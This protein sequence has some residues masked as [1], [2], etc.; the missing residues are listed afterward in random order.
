MAEAPL[1]ADGS[2]EHDKLRVY[3]GFACIHCPFRTISRQLMRRHLSSP[4]D[5]CRFKADHARPRPR[6][7]LD[8]QFECVY[9]QTWTTGSTRRYWII[10]RGGSAVRPVDGPAVQAHLR[11]VL[12]RELDR[13]QRPAAAEP[14][15]EMT[16]FALQRPWMERTGWDQTYR[17]RGR[18]QVLAAMTRTFT[19]PGGQEYLLGR[20]GVCGLDEDLVS[21][22]GD[23]DRIASLVRLADVMI[24]RCE[25]TVRKTSRHVLCWLR[26]TQTSSIYSK[27]FTLV[28]QASSSGKYRLLLKRCLAMVF[29]LYRMPPDTR[30]QAAG[31]A[32]NK[33]QLQCLDAIWTH[34]ADK[35][36]EDDEEVEEEDDEEV[37]EYNEEDND[38]KEDE[39]REFTTWMNNLGE[40][41]D[42]EIPDE[43]ASAGAARGSPEELVELLFGLTLAL[44]TQPV[45][46]GQPQTTVLIYFSGI[47]GFSSSPDSAFLPA[48]SYTSNLSGLIYILRLIFLEYAL[49]LQAYPTLALERRPRMGQLDR[50]Q[51]IRRQ[52]MVM[53]SQSPLEELLSLRNFGYVISRTDTPPCLLRWSDNG[54]VV[55]L[56]EEISISM[57]QFRRLPEHFIKEAAGLCTE[58]MFSWDPAID[59]AS[60]KDDMTNNEEGFSF[61]LHPGNKLD[62]AYL[63]LC[64]R[65]SRAHRHGL[66]RSGGWDWNAVFQYLKKEEALRAAILGGMFCAGGQQPRCTEVLS[67]LCSNGELHPRGIYVYDR[68]MIYITRHHKAKRATNREFVV[69][70]FLPAQLGHILYKYL[71][72]IRPFIDMLHRE[73]GSG[74]SGEAAVESPLLFREEVVIPSRPWQTGRL[75]AILKGATSTV[76]GKPVNSRQ[77]RQIC[78]GVSE[79]HVRESGHR[80]LQRGA[81][82][83]L[84]G[85]FPTKLQPQLLELY[86]WA[87]SRWHEF[88]HLPS[89]AAHVPAAEGPFRRDVLSSPSTGCRDSDGDEDGDTGVTTSVVAS[90]ARVTSGWSCSPQAAERHPPV[91]QAL[92]WSSCGPA[93][94]RATQQQQIRRT[95]RDPSTSDGS[96]DGEAAGEKEDAVAFF[97]RIYRE[98]QE[99]F[100]RESLRQRQQQAARDE[101]ARHDRS[102]KRS[103]HQTSGSQD[104]APRP[105]RSR[106]LPLPLSLERGRD[107]GPGRL[108]QASQVGR[109]P[110]HDDRRYR[111]L[112][113]HPSDLPTTGAIDSLQ[114]IFD[115]LR[116]RISFSNDNN[117]LRARIKLWKLGDRLEGW[118]TVGC[119]FCFIN[120][121]PGL[122][123]TIDDCAMIGSDT[124]RRLL[125]WL[126]TLH[127]DRFGRTYGLCSLCTEDS[128]VCQEV[129]V[130]N[131]ICCAST[132]DEKNH[133]RQRRDSAA[134]PDG[135]CENK[136]V[137]RRTIAALCTS[138]DQILGKALTKFISEKDG[139]DLTAESQAIEWFERKVP[140]RETWVPQ[141]LVVLDI[142]VAAFD[143]LRGRRRPDRRAD[144]GHDGS[145]EYGWKVVMDWW[146]G[147]CSFCAGRGVR[148][149]QIEHALRQCPFGG[150]PTLRMGLAEAIYKEG[151][152]ALGGC[153]GCA[154]PRELCQAWSKSA[155]GR[156][157]RDQGIRCQY[158][159]QAYDTAIGFFYCKERKYRDELMESMADAGLE[160]FDEEEVASWLGRKIIVAGIES[161]EIMRQLR[162]W[163]GILWD[164]MKE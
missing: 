25:E 10:K 127:L 87:S 37:E 44:A 91:R 74:L 111:P 26:S 108:G 103:I 38:N 29:R 149:P 94:G 45:I 97:K 112:F 92:V 6:R 75:T 31:L 48:R 39:D 85:A 63:E 139:V 132:E 23:E 124:A 57:G 118:S 135:L 125:G 163:S 49:P 104:A 52:Y 126:E 58:M 5:D 84:D 30:I 71:V 43:E 119:Q 101:P 46:D 152:W 13:R 53:E 69:A 11:A 24:D 129:V 131:Q 100:E 77:F 162:W 158:G 16:A 136:L 102:A 89:H 62:T 81:T 120:D 95:D 14:A 68:S 106:T 17:G 3:E 128:Q 59:L 20:R 35:E 160:N 7:D 64:C 144:S 56:G 161:S 114:A 145:S 157:K 150:K 72:Y 98:D 159:R 12:T 21:P 82:Y 83:G 151:M 93:P 90:P 123:H 1:R 134:G 86:R 66:L 65:A 122:D 105:K 113:G 40:I 22:G 110:P 140:H 121:E 141:L 50:L 70:R 130:A 55:S 41:S 142:L 96:W 54:Q 88:L 137:I 146:V 107:R 28:Q 115:H 36:E 76:W 8:Q 156:W 80:P 154:L 9:L 67:L 15:G 42:D 147:K 138:D 78:I 60:I 117:A 79:K 99:A 27:P 155:S 4:P 109:D 116:G 19:S 143:L 73:R 18:R 61:V 133:W 148:G 33:K 34:E 47:L 51:P 32:L 153:L 2:S 164:R